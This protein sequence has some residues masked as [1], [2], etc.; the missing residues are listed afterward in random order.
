MKWVD[1]TETVSVDSLGDVVVRGMRLSD[2]LRLSQWDEAQDGP[3]SRQFCAVL[4]ATVRAPDGS[5]I[6]T[7]DEWDGWGGENIEDAVRLFDVAQRLSG[8]SADD[9]KKKSSPRKSGSR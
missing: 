7:N 4:A 3:K 5:A 1:R 6:F 8:L 2:K 9:A